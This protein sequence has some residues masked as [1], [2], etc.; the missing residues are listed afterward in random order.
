MKKQTRVKRSAKQCATSYL[1]YQFQC[2][3]TVFFPSEKVP[4]LLFFPHI[5]IAAR[6]RKKKKRGTCITFR[7]ITNP[8]YLTRA[9]SL[10]L[11]TQMCL[12]SQCNSQNWWKYVVNI[13][14]LISLDLAR[15]LTFGYSLRWVYLDMIK[16]LYISR[17]HIYKLNF[18]NS[19]RNYSNTV[20][21]KNNESLAE[22]NGFAH[23]GLLQLE[24]PWLFLPEQSWALTDPAAAP[25]CWGAL[26]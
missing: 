3:E 10:L 24:E 9:D 15:I 16:C 2:G 13:T 19:V 22:W 25:R 26:L 1:S 20:I 18:I 5:M 12:L 6:K 8:P 14:T 11:F 17:P 4:V 21:C 23:L 7:C